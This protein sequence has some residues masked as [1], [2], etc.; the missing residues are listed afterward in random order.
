[1]YPYW[2]HPGEP[3]LRACDAVTAP[4]LKKLMNANATRISFD[5]VTSRS[6]HSG[7]VVNVLLMDGSV[8]PVTSNINL[9]TWRALGSRN[10]GE[11]IGDF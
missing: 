5:A 10:G 9:A 1:M 2:D 6:Y 11:V 3:L 7:G 8:R 4:K